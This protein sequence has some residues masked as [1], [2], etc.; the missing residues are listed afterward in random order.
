[1]RRGSIRLGTILGVPVAM[2]L[3]VVVV[4]GLLAW[5]LATGVLPSSDPGLVDAVYWSVGLLGAFAFLASLLCHEMA[6][7]VVARRHQVEVEGVT[8]WM[9]GGYA[10]FASQ[11]RTPG[12]EFQISAAGPLASLACALGAT[13]AAFGLDW[14]G[15]APVYT[16]AFAWIAV[17]NGLLFV[18]NLLPGSPLDGGRILASAIW[19]IRGSEASGRIGAA[20]TGRFLGAGLMA[21]GVAQLLFASALG[22]WTAL[23]GWFL[24]SAAT[25]EQRYF[26]NER[27]LGDIT[28]GQAMTPS[29]Q[30]AQSWATISS[31]VDGPLRRTFQSAVP[32]LDARSVLIGVVSMSD[33]KR[34][35]AEQWS[36]RTAADLLSGRSPAIVAEPDERLADLLD[37]SNGTEPAV[38]MRGG[39]VLGIVGAEEL[40]RTLAGLNGGPPPTPE[41]V[42]HQHWNPPAPPGGH[43]SRN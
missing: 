6:H 2:D 41:S 25:A 26:V 27:S 16:A 15:V 20:I 9:L 38:V 23:I 34:V 19:K 4:T 29:T 35:P 5:S 17:L 36:S 40:R 28:V 8:L 30:V 11:P 22:I 37:R 7:A 12:A 14:L 3:G 33:V 18:F 32:V 10:Q 24:Y 1:M 13:G 43:P 42:P 39:E 21:L 31:L